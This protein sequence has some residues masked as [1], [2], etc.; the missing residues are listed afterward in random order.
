MILIGRKF[1]LSSS[2]SRISINSIAGSKAAGI[3]ELG[4]CMILIRRKFVVHGCLRL[5]LRDCLLSLKA[6]RTGI[7]H[8]D[9]RD[10]LGFSAPSPL[11]HQTIRSW[12]RS[13][14]NGNDPTNE[15]AAL[16]LAISASLAST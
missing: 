16:L 9:S 8:L 4:L 1:V 13:H 10:Q 15:K 2:F 12:P 7:A 3:S 11:A 5:V 6:P 14:E